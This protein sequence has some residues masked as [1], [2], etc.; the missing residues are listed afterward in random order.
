M[1]R[2]E[3][4]VWLNS[5]FNEALGG[6]IAEVLLMGPGIGSDSGSALESKNPGAFWQTSLCSHQFKYNQS[7]GVGVR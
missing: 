7:G 4:L 6:A 1:Q 3:G 2:E 5:G